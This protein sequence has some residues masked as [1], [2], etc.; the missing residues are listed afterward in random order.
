MQKFTLIKHACLAITLALGLTEGAAANTYPKQPVRIVVPFAAAGTTDLIA[1]LIGNPLGKA[2]GQPV[3]VE[4]KAG[5]GGNI[6]AEYV[7]RAQPDGYVLQLGTAG[8]LTVNPAIYKNLR[9]DP[10]KD[11]QPISLIATLPNMMVVNK[12][13][14]ANTVQE[15]VAWAKERPGEVFFASA[16]TGSTLHLTGELFNMTAGVQMSQVPYKGSAPALAD[17]VGGAGPVVMFDNMPSAIGLVRSGAL[18][19]LAVTGPESAK[20]APEIPTMMQ[21]GYPDF[22]VVT[23][24]ALFAPA[25]TPQDIVQRLNQE[26]VKIVNTPEIAQQLQALG[27]TPMSSTPEELAEVV[28]ADT[29]RWGEV[30]K[31]AKIDVQ[32]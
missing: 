9:F 1:R 2:L 31:A 19:A 15:F 24:F 18:R 10:I 11:F 32:L 14:P 22:N 13:V 26:I 21:S 23:W 20:S 8:N 12:K 3:I 7:A 25:G 27:S 28:K 30:I 5:A 4:N 6:G 17:L 16:G 29:Q